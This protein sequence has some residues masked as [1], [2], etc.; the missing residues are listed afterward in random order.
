[1]VVAMVVAFVSVCATNATTMALEAVPRACVA[2]NSRYAGG[3]RNASLAD[4]V[5]GRR[6][7]KEARGT[8]SLSSTPQFE[9]A[10]APASARQRRPARL[11]PHLGQD[12]LEPRLR[13]RV[14]V[15]HRRRHR[16]VALGD[17]RVHAMRDGAVARM[18]L[19]A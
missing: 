1:M 3:S 4:V 14:H 19:D 16:G 11:L 10:A 15:R 2:A 18:S 8:P 5:T 12:P 13:R 7:P 6:E 17:Q 9:P